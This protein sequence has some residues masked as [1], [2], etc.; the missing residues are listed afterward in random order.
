LKFVK[1]KIEKPAKKIA[2]NDIAK[3]P[4]KE[5]KPVA[6][7]EPLHRPSRTKKSPDKLREEPP[8]KCKKLAKASVGVEKKKTAKNSNKE[9]KMTVDMTNSS[10]GAETVKRIKGKEIE[11]KAA[12]KK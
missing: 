6:A 8:P 2:P 3:Q 11:K 12:A 1:N 4:A 7:A 10:K 5:K 9:L